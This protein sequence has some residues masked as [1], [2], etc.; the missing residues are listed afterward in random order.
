MTDTILIATYTVS[1]TSEA[2]LFDEFKI[3]KNDV[4]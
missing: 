2:T 4:F 3:V 1:N